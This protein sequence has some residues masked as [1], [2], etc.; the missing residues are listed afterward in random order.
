MKVLKVIGW[1]IFIIIA[2]IIA[3]LAIMEYY[4]S[5]EDPNYVL[6]YIKEHKNEQTCSLMIRRNGEIL[7]TVNENKKLPLASMAKIVV[8]VEF[9]KQVSE[10]KI[11]PQEQIP[12]QDLEKYY[13][14]DT[15]AGA[16]PAW[17]EDAKIRNAIKNEKLSLEE[18]ARGMIHFSSNANTTYLLEKLGLERINNS[19]KELEL[20]S[21]DAFYPYTSPLY[22]RGY[23]EKELNVPKDQSLEVLRKMSMD[24][25]RKHALKIHEWMK[26]EAE[27]KKHNIP[28][29][30]DM[31]FQRIWS[32]RLVRATAKDYMSLIGKINNRTAFPKP[33]QDE[34]E[35]IFN[36]TVGD[37]IY[38]HAGKKGGSTPFV[39]TNSFYGTDKEGNKVEIVFMSNDLDSMELQKL[40][41]N[42]DYF[43]RSVVMSE[44][45]RK[46]L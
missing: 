14:P 29:K 23:V 33:M 34:I 40:K 38:E 27:W 42:V 43:I 30:V 22:M 12:L 45:F 4:Y 32:D 39:L 21:H 7:A 11:N 35:K 25:Y 46:K 28:L 31:E 20:N 36:G 17:L 16:H 3:I 18:V 9:E 5:K 24:E 37:S 26:D 44:E 6:D 1:S 15:D 13:V 2:I 8:A 19:L 41:N 10:E